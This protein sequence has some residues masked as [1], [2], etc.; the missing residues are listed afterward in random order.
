M[1][2]RIWIAAKKIV[3][4]LGQYRLAI[5]NFI[6]LGLLRTTDAL[7]LLFLIPVIISRVGIDNFGIIAF[8]QVFL[9]YGKTVVNYGFNI[10]GVQEV[11]L[12]ARD[13]KA[14]SRIF[15]DILF[16]R[17]AIALL[18]G[19]GLAGLVAAIPYLRGYW[20]TFFW[21]YFLV[22]GQIVYADWFFIGLQKAKYLTA[23]NLLA[24]LLFAL[25]VV[26][27]IRQ[28]AGHIYVIGLQG[29]A[30]LFT[31]LLVV[32][33]LKYRYGL[34]LLWPRGGATLH[35]LRSDFKLLVTNLS[36]EVNTSYSL[37][38]INILT[39][40]ALTG[41]FSIM[42]KLIQ[43]LRFLLV[44]FSQALFPMACERVKKGWE[45]LIGLLRQAIS[46]FI[47]LPVA[48]TALMLIFAGPLLAYF[49]G[50]P[51]SLLVSSFRIYLLVPLAVLANIPPYQILL[52]YGR[53]ADYSKV[54]ILGTAGNLILSFVLARS[55]GLHGLVSALLLVEVFI[56]L[57][58][59]FMV[60]R[61]KRE[62]KT[63]SQD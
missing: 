15:S 48:I 42:Q 35:Y 28:P 40:N 26:L 59:Y 1:K 51:D 9:N 7:V 56:T 33:L 6:S 37:L 31:G 3:S 61:N 58:L 13:K 41:Y 29:G 63:G 18:V 53:K 11:V 8:V 43:P 20:A 54:Y 21:G 44:I 60:W 46:L 34:S 39:T 52:A 50:P 23:A 19:M 22:L 49:A 17:A 30:V 10:S 47:L 5:A 32:A 16:T 55:Y 27:L 57:G 38:V 25:L 24:K 12:H 4:L 2:E 45:E 62:M 14:L 36:I